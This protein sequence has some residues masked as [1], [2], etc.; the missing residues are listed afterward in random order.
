MKEQQFN[1]L[2]KLADE[3]KEEFPRSKLTD[4]LK[5][6]TFDEWVPLIGKKAKSS[7]YY[8]LKISS[9]DTL[10]DEYVE[11]ARL[12]IREE[13]ALGGYRLADWLVH[14]LGARSPAEEVSE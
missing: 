9:G 8:D 3:L 10:T 6:K 5:L 11:Q 2:E 7:A 13:I 1:D 4:L 14:N 12:T